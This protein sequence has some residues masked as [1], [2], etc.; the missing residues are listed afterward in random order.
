MV[1]VRESEKGTSVITLEKGDT[2]NV[3]NTPRNGGVRIQIPK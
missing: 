1:S 3:E 2:A